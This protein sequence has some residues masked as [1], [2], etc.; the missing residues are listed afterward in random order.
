MKLS[1]YNILATLFLLTFLVMFFTI[2]EEVVFGNLIVL[3]VFA[4]VWVAGYAFTSMSL[5]ELEDNEIEKG[6]K[7]R[8]KW[9]G[10]YLMT[11]VFF[12]LVTMLYFVDYFY[13]MNDIVLW[14][15]IVSILLFLV[16]FIMSYIVDVVVIEE[17]GLIISSF[18]RPKKMKVAYNEIERVAFGPLMNTLKIYSKGKFH[19]VDITLKNSKHFIN[20]LAANTPKEL[21][22]E[23][24][25]ALG[26]YYNSFGVK[27]NKELIDFFAQ[28]EEGEVE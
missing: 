13:G 6:Y 1:I 28:F 17:D 21:H 3:G 8:N 15:I 2:K 10:L 5:L 16:Y 22:A 14:I 11:F 25:L 9:W 27:K 4:V 7:H 26:R 20:A 23:A 19:I 18:L 24:Y 12:I